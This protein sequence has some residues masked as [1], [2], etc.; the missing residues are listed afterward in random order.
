MSDLF[1]SPFHPA[2]RKQDV[3]SPLTPAQASSKELPSIDWQKTSKEL[4]P[5]LIIYD[6]FGRTKEY[7]H[8]HMVA[9]CFIIGK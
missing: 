6:R 1:I 5:E 4:T 2:W 7:R 8:D 9:T 3:V